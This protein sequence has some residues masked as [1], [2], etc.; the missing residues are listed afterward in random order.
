MAIKANKPKE[1]DEFRNCSL[2]SRAGNRS[3]AAQAALSISSRAS[4]QGDPAQAAGTAVPD[5]QGSRAG[6]G[7]A[8]PLSPGCSASGAAPGAA[9]RSWV[10]LAV[11]PGT[12]QWMLQRDQ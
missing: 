9:W 4:E 5:V 8:V 3:A 6:T 12:A 1:P 10:Q 11:L 7:H 2:G